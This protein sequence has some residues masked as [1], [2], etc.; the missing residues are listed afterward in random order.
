ME[1][2][3]ISRL[4]AARTCQ[5]LHHYR[6]ELGYR[7][8]V[9]ADALR[10]GTLIHLGLEAWWKAPENHLRLPHAFEAVQQV[11]ADPF[12][13]VRARV[14]LTG[15]HARWED[16]PYEVLGVEVQFDAPM[17]NPATGHPS[18][19]YR[20]GGKIDAIVRDTRDGRTLIVEHK[21]TSEDVSGGS[22]YWKRLRLDGQV[23]TYFDGAKALGFDVAGCVYDVLSKPS[24][25][26]HR[27]TPPESRKYTKDG[28]LYANQREHDETPEEFGERLRDAILADP[29][30][31][32]ARAEV[33]RLDGE[34]D[35]ARFDTWQ[36]AE[37]IREGARLG[38]HPRSPNSCIRF[39]STC[40]Y[41]SVCT[42]EAS[43]DDP[44]RF[45]RS[46]TQHPELSATP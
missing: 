24:L 37:I 6:Y 43:L 42:K 28:K 31:Y 34:L 2:I 18:R 33:A 38:R 32:F 14:M 30:A 8:A 4:S 27:A 7:P 10:F 12:D 29:S 5:R 39:G 25:R 45:R 21:T 13:R 46:E 36:T 17:V 3:T 11:D 19:T 16:E 15:Y 23:S 44:S 22:D 40:P 41:W 35:E 20:L 9:E 1:L 26:P